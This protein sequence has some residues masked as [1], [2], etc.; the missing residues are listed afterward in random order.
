M[1]KRQDME[2]GVS[3]SSNAG[4]Q[5]CDTITLARSLSLIHIFV[6][7]LDGSQVQA[8]AAAVR[9]FV[10]AKTAQIHRFA[11]EQEVAIL[12]CR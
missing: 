12:N 1:Y 4:K 10:L 7:A 11:V 8:A 9:I 5:T 3:V 6:I 2:Q